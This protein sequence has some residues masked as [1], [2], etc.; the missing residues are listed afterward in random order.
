MI[1]ITLIGEFPTMN[2]FIDAAKRVYNV[3]KAKTSEYSKMKNAWSKDVQ[4]M[5]KNMPVL[6]ECKDI[7]IHWYRKSKRTDKDNIVAG[8]KVILDGMIQAG[9]LKNDGWKEIGCIHNDYFVNKQNPRVEM[10]FY[11]AG[12]ISDIMREK[13]EQDKR[14]KTDLRRTRDDIK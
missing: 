11:S 12:E 7:V 2:Q 13:I 10:Y 8:L 1:Q 9:K 3:G 4:W 14:L 5:V 6:E